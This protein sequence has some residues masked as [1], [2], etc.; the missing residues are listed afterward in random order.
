MAERMTAT[1][2][3]EEHDRLLE[4]NAALR[5]RVAELE[6]GLTRAEA[7]DGCGVLRG[8]HP[9]YC[10][11]P[12]YERDCG[13]HYEPDRCGEWAPVSEI[14]SGLRK[15]VA[16]LEATARTGHEAMVAR[17]MRRGEP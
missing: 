10:G 3:Y 1:Q 16:K 15:H 11:E 5:A 17:Y 2:L 4:H 13:D 12:M 14:V 8:V 7:C 9:E 6:A